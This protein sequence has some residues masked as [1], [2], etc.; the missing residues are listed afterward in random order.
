MKI[1][2]LNAANYDDH[3]HWEQRRATIADAF[4]RRRPDV[5]ML[6]EVRFDPARAS[7]RSTGLDM[8]SQLASD[9][10]MQCCL[11]IAQYYD[12]SDNYRPCDRVTSVW[13]GLAVLTRERPKCNSSLSLSVPQWLD[14][15]HRIVQ[16]IELSCGL[17]LY[18]VHLSTAEAE[19]RAQLDC[20]LDWVFGDA[21]EKRSL[22]AGDFNA[23]PSVISEVLQTRGLCDAWIKSQGT[24]HSGYTFPSNAPTKRIDYVWLREGDLASRLETCDLVFEQP[25]AGLYA[26]DHLGLGFVLSDT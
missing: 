2:V 7:T 16:R 25:V 8:A 17:V 14:R 20:I 6:Q 5:V 18:N 15:N 4:L 13:E 22:L 3:P 9:L 12:P 1:A 11:A 10:G 21:S 23:E 26:S 24:S 19:G